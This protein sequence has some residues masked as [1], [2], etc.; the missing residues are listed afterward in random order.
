MSI[1]EHTSLEKIDL[2]SM[3][4]FLLADKVRFIFDK[5][6]RIVIIDVVVECMRHFCRKILMPKKPFTDYW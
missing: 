4:R 2:E 3:V 5:I 6:Q 1:H